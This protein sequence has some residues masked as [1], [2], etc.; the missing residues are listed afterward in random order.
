MLS[1]TK[2]DAM[3]FSWILLLLG[4]VAYFSNLAAQDTVYVE[5]P[6][7]TRPLEIA[8]GLTKKC[9]CYDAFEDEK[10]F[11][12]FQAEF[13]VVDS[14]VVY[15]EQKYELP[16]ENKPKPSESGNE[17]KM[18]MG[19]S[20]VKFETEV[21]MITTYKRDD[22]YWLRTDYSL[23]GDALSTTRIQRRINSEAQYDFQTIYREREDGKIYPEVIGSGYY[24]M[25]KN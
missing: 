6:E 12:T 17:K 2:I 25:T 11:V 15:L 14:C 18:G 1:L 3:K 10:T 24:P 20:V 19:M 21:L 22:D 16:D 23:S 4:G 9:R 8:P 13:D 7:F 5:K